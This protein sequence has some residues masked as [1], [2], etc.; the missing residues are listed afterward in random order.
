MYIYI[1]IYIHIHTYIYIYI[2][3]NKPPRKAGATE[4]AFHVS[5]IGVYLL[6][7]EYSLKIEQEKEIK[8]NYLYLHC[9]ASTAVAYNK[10][11]SGKFALRVFCVETTLSC[12]ACSVPTRYIFLYTQ[13]KCVGGDHLT[14]CSF[15]SA[16]N[17]CNFNSRPSTSFPL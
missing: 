11:D 13:I 7:F 14:F 8:L 17:L 16:V 2:P 12:Q 10:S 3:I 15:L 1:Y 6:D 4:F 9:V 5:V